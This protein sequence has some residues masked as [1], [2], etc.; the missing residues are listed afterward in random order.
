MGAIMLPEPSR[1][2]EGGTP[3]Q[4]GMSAGR[5]MRG[6]LSGYRSKRIDM[7]RAEL[8]QVDL[9]MRLDC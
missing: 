8:A 5:E 9:D 6:R 7:S 1:S 3:G 2:Q 4:V